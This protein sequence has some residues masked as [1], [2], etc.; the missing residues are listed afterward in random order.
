MELFVNASAS[1][2]HESSL[3]CKMLSDCIY[4]LPYKD[5]TPVQM[6]YPLNILGVKIKFAFLQVFALILD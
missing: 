2:S 1:S 4:I 5:K 3:R 6:I